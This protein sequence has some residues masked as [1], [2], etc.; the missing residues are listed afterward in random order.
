MQ[1][2]P[3]YNKL[4]VVKLREELVRRGLPK[5]GLKP[6]LVN[7]LLEADAQTETQDATP[8]APIPDAPAIQKD[9]GKQTEPLH[10]SQAHIQGRGTMNDNLVPADTPE[11]DPTSATN[12]GSLQEPE[13]LTEA[14]A[15]IRE[16][17]RS[18]D[19]PRPLDLQPPAVVHAVTAVEEVAPVIE[20][21]STSH[22]STD[23]RNATLPRSK[24]TDTAATEAAPTGETDPETES[25]DQSLT[26]APDSI[27]TT[28]FSQVLEQKPLG[29]A[30][31]VAIQVTEA[32]SIIETK[33][34]SIPVE[35]RASPAVPAEALQVI[36]AEETLHK[37]VT[38]KIPENK[39][40]SEEA[41]KFVDTQQ[42]LPP[43]DPGK[44]MKE[45]QENGSTKR[46][47]V[48]AESTPGS[49]PQ[50]DEVRPSTIGAEAMED[51]KKRKRRSQSPP[52]L[53]E[54]IAQKRARVDDSKPNV[55]LPEDSVMQDMA[56]SRAK[57]P[58]DASRSG[59]VPSDLPE[60]AHKEGYT[61][62]P[63]KEETAGGRKSTSNEGNE[64]PQSLLPGKGPEPPK[65][66]E[67]QPDS[68]DDTPTQTQ[69]EDMTAKP[70]P[71]DTRFKKL[72]SAPP[73]RPASPVRQAPYGE[74]EDRSI[75]PALHPATSALY[76]RD[77]MRPLHPSLLKD[78]LI[79][80]ATRASLS[81]SASPPSQIIKEFF[82]DP[83]RTHCL[84]GFTSTAAASRVRSSLHNRVWP[85]ERG[86]RPLWV[87][88]VPE[89]K[90][91]KWI[92]VEKDVRSQK[93]Q[94]AKRWEVVY[95]E[96]EGHI[97]AYL[98]EA[99]SGPRPPLSHPSSRLQSDAPQAAP[100]VAGA[101]LGPRS[102][103][104]EAS[105]PFQQ[106][107]QA[108]AQSADVGKG[109]QALDDLFQSTNTKPKLYYLPVS[110][111]VA[112]KR[113]EQLGEGKGGG[114]SGNEIRK[115]T[116]E[117]EI[118]VD[119]GADFSGRSRGGFGGGR[120]G[121]GGGG[122]GGG[123]S[124]R[125]DGWRERARERG[126]DEV[127]QREDALRESARREAWPE[128]GRGDSFRERDRPGA[129]R[130]R[131]REVGWRGPR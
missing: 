15:I 59:P 34:S 43:S 7:R 62:T 69:S 56:D 94:G 100:G 54:E 117:G 8:D 78:H 5:T 113:L 125:G 60:S 119:R 72:F 63:A 105:R 35:R 57:K 107:K 109:F 50:D 41:V 29:Q 23:A 27:Q 77:F 127:W 86:R 9:S 71:H 118:L 45:V 33:V 122:G 84:V 20:A 30:I 89:E 126:R 110:K 90:L 102:R 17:E 131:D 108:S 28:V 26:Q 18:L 73:D 12:N 104:P 74:D 67:P 40:A 81:P 32:H 25:K 46:P 61:K 116:F 112:D 114:R 6:V 93:G 64:A 65:D 42:E 37:V 120:R 87:D 66:T 103:A 124:Y 96:E 111:A 1:K 98:Q 39:G 16:N 47:D 10:R 83:I 24:I 121:R 128:K 79:A 21:S 80:L 49:T 11:Q 14:P 44:N 68:S 70:S 13:P 129:W 51:N 123:G 36:E 48:D 31:G 19:A 85:D 58:E 76:I 4:T 106:Q 91:R 130:E 3:D 115:Y 38:S 22:M 2:M 75:S 88:F 52:P 82:L 101:P 92:E 95:E 99:G 55:I 53:S 97:K